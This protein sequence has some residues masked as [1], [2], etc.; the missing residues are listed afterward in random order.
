MPLFPFNLSNYALGLTRIRLV[1]YAI[2]SFVCMAPAAT[3]FTWLGHAGYTWLGHAG[4]E[5][6]LERDASAINYGLAALGLLAAIVFVPRLIGRFRR[7]AGQWIEAQELSRA[8]GD[9]APVTV[10]DVRGPDEFEGPLGHISGALNLPLGELESRSDELRLM[11]K[12][13]ITLVCRTDKRSANASAM[14]RT[15]GFEQVSVLRGGTERWNALGL[16]IMRAAG[17][18]AAEIGEEAQR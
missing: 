16:P 6:A 15:A 14:L 10:L 5:A 1:P 11:A 3:A 4:R 9:G 8:L 7:S 17:A 18:D 13:R 12:D 2:T